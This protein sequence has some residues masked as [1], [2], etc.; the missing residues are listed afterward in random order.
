MRWLFLLLLASSIAAVPIDV[1]Q[2]TVTP[3]WNELYGIVSVR[4]TPVGIFVVLRQ[5]Q[6]RV[7]LDWQSSTSS[8]VIDV[9]H[10][11]YNWWD[12]AATAFELHPDYPQQ[13]YGYLR[14]AKQTGWG[15]NCQRTDTD[16]RLYCDTSSVLL[17][18]TLNNELQAIDTFVLLDDMCNSSPSHDGGELRFVGSDLLWTTGDAAQFD[19]LDAGTPFDAC[20]NHS[21]GPLQGV[22]RAQRNDFVQGKVYLIPS[23]L[24]LVNRQLSIHE[25]T[26]V[27]KGLRN[28]FRATVDPLTQHVYL[29]DVG[30]S[31]WEEINELDLSNT[32]IVNFGWPCFEGLYPH[33]AYTNLGRDICQSLEFA[34][35]VHAYRWPTIDPNHP[36]LCQTGDASISGLTV[37]TGTAF[38][39]NAVFAVDGA[40]GCV[41]FFARSIDGNVDWSQAHT[42]IHN[43][44][45]YTDIVQGDDNDLYLAEYSEHRVVRVAAVQTSNPPPVA[46]LQATSS[47]T[48]TAPLTV[49]WDASQSLDNDAIVRYE[50]DFGNGQRQTTVSP[51]T[52]HTYTTKGIYVASVR[53]V[54]AAEQGTMSDTVT[55]VVDPDYQVTMSPPSGEWCVTDILQY[56]LEMQE[57]GTTEVDWKVETLHCVSVP[58]GPPDCHSHTMGFVEGSGRTSGSFL[59]VPHPLPSSIRLTLTLRDESFPAP[60]VQEFETMAMGFDWNFTS[61]VTLD[62]NGKPCNNCTMQVMCN[63]HVP[64]QAPLRAFVGDGDEGV[65]YVFESWNVIDYFRGRQFVSELTTPY[66]K[67]PAQGSADLVAIYNQ[68]TELEGYYASPVGCFEDDYLGVRFFADSQTV[69]T[70]TNTPERCALFCHTQGHVYAGVEFGVE[71]FCGTSLGEKPRVDDFRCNMPCSGDAT[72]T[73]GA[74]NIIQVYAIVQGTGT[75]TR[76]PI[77]SPTGMPSLSP[78][79]NSPTVVPTFLPTSSSPTLGPSSRATSSPTFSPS[80]VPTSSPTSRPTAKESSLPSSSKTVNPTQ[81]VLMPREVP[82]ESPSISPVTE[83]PSQ[84]EETNS[85]TLEGTIGETSYPTPYYGDFEFFTHWP[86]PAINGVRSTA[87]RRSGVLVMCVI[88]MFMFLT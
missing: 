16:A 7:F 63:N 87:P 5:G 38:S 53:A 12:H 17:R 55:V 57:D 75:P 60:I 10:Q 69:F 6:V 72:Q 62:V 68:V 61:V 76:Y 70:N 21:A 19:G 42:F 31:A 47:T 86:S 84:E 40:R 77:M 36:N 65:A 8:L 50:W 34:R 43:G 66:I 30:Q 52:S 23:N 15:D 56:A 88:S 83:A 32:E 13:P 35:P 41:W 79:T 2:V 74:G 26:L 82:T 71:C 27:A 11:A 81:R 46:H 37:Y 80:F 9:S 44:G 39:E 48:G 73:C 4:P 64:V 45:Y 29:G 25:L 3:H 18:I 14:I 28:P 49:D 1:S 54:D 59:P 33:V 67:R 85:P 22:Y 58:D 51:V 78:V 24:L 20:Y